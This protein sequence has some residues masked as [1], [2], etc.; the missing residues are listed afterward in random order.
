ME[1]AERAL[2]ESEEQLRILF[3]S[4]PVGMIVVDPV[5]LKFLQVN[6]KALELSGFTREEFDHLTVLDFEAHFPPDE[7]SARG[8]KYSREGWHQFDTRIR[9]RQ[10]KL[11]DLRVTG[12]SVQLGGRPYLLQI[13]EDISASKIL[14]RQLM[15][16]KDAAEEASRAKGE[17]LANMSHEI[18]TPLTVVMACLE[19]LLGTCAGAE[20]QDLL[21]LANSSADRLHALIE[22][23]LDLSRIEARHLEV[24]CSAFN[25]RE[26]VGSAIE[27]LRLQAENKGL[28]LRCEIDPAVPATANAD[29]CRLSQVL[30][31]LIGNAVKFT[32]AGAVTVR[33]ESTPEGLLFS[34][35]DT[36]IGIAESNR[37]RLFQSFSQIDSSL[38]RKY[39]GTGLGLAISKTLVELMGGS[40]WLESEEGIGS[41]FSFTLPTNPTTPAGGK[42]GA[43]EKST[44]SSP[45]VVHAGRLLLV[46]DDPRVRRV[47]R[48][49]L[50]ERGWEVAIAASG[51]EAVQQWL[52]G[53]IDLILM[54]LQM[55]DT[56]G[57][58]VT[59]TIREQEA[60]IGGRIPI[61]ALTAHVRP[62]DRESCRAAG[63][64]DFL[65]KPVT[66]DHLFATID[67]HLRSRRR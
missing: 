21:Q 1:P 6:R 23:V 67:I 28:E 30:T 52:Q 4:A 44:T 19:H 16:A 45:G 57:L 65:S 35:R 40:I 9:T 60:K 55:P 38:T 54:D 7:V 20:Q 10:G 17:F 26:C 25:V 11:H 58:E 47:L 33:L 43:R 36:G 39:G 24:S 41:V 66:R 48:L 31:N 61:V 42:F 53:G 14:E 49:M 13:I 50:S 37:D 2:R 63:M 15:Q 56:N 5:D 34:V 46:E 27:L 22:D 51:E 12:E 59:R 18:R 8:Q 29:P 64:D 62:E 32:A 3:D